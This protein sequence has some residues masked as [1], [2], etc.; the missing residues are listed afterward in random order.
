MPIL[1]GHFPAV[2]RGTIQR[3]IGEGHIRVNGRRTKPA[4]HP[5]AGEEITVHWPEPRPAEAQ[6]EEMPLDVLFEDSTICWC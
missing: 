5:Q 3:L 6:A 1:T 2:S 4:H